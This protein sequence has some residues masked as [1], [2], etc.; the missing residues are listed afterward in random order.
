VLRLLTTRENDDHT[1]AL[2]DAWATVLDVLT[3]YNERFINEG[4]LRTAA[5]RLSLVELARHIS[6]RP[7]PG[8][9]ASTWLAFSMDESPGAPLEAI[10]PIGMKVQSI[11][12]QDEKPQIFESI[13]EILAKTKWNAIKPKLK[14]TQVLAKGSTQ[15]YLQGTSTQLQIGDRLLIVGNERISNSGSERWDIRAIQSITPDEKANHTLVTWRE[16]LGHDHPNINPATDNVKV[17]VFRQRAAL[18]GY[19][20]P[21]IRIMSTG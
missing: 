20:A 9:A 15:L 19:N 21:D 11:P 2:I 14:E 16:G 5:E 6:Y 4:Y 7:K 12:G 18:F 8:V 3:F 10:A 1:I 13:E 17:Y